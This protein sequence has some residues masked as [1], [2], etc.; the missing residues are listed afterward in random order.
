VGVNANMFQSPVSAIVSGDLMKRGGD[1][2]KSTGLGVAIPPPNAAPTNSK[3]WPLE[4]SISTVFVDDYQIPERLNTSQNDRIVLSYNRGSTQRQQTFSKVSLI[5][6]AGSGLSLV[7]TSLPDSNG[8]ITK[9]YKLD[10]PLAPVANLQ[11]FVEAVNDWDAGGDGMNG[12]SLDLQIQVWVDLPHKT[13]FQAN[14]E[15]VFFSQYLTRLAELQPGYIRTGPDWSRNNGASDTRLLENDPMAE[16]RFDAWDPLAEPRT[17]PADP[18]WS[19]DTGVPWE[20][21]AWLANEMTS[22]LWV[23]IPF[24]Y[25]RTTETALRDQAKAYIQALATVLKN[26]LGPDQH[27]I[28]EYSNEMWNSNFSSRRVMN[29]FEGS[30]T[31]QK[32]VRLV[33]DAFTWWWEVWSDRRVE[34]VVMGQA[35][36]EMWASGIADDLAPLGL[37][38]A[39]GCALYYQPRE[40]DQFAWGDEN[41]AVCGVNPYVPPTNEELRDSVLAMIDNNDPGPGGQMLG[42]THAVRLHGDVVA[43]LNTITIGAPI[44]MYAYEGGPSYLTTCLDL[45]P[46]YK[47]FQHDS[48]YNYDLLDHMM[49]RFIDGIGLG[50]VDPP[51]SKL[52]D[53]FVYFAFCQSQDPVSGDFLLL[54]DL[55]AGLGL[56][57]SVDPFLQHKFDAVRDFNSVH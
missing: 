24:I 32:F 42:L 19:A 12:E 47:D 8:V 15:E 51:V 43:Y 7:L 17:L 21:H 13:A 37:V 52:L 36:D 56:P 2:I 25:Y 22:D 34:F 31:P 35:A 16:L 41:M 48:P 28:V 27:C 57:G 39:I 10:P 30:V 14:P 23:C 50:Q 45:Q 20:V 11:V 55:W 29:D 46:V 18:L 49:E 26:E 3:G 33:Q 4:R 1:W 38:D 53:V 6:T 40:A 54:T 5:G 9:H 44:K